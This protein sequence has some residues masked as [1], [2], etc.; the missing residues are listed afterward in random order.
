MDIDKDRTFELEMQIYRMAGTLR[1]WKMAHD[2]EIEI[3]PGLP[4]CTEEVIEAGYVI[5]GRRPDGYQGTESS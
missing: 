1:A 5:A 3:P 4:R 2:K